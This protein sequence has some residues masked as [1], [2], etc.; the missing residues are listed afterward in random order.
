M[1]VLC[2]H[3][4]LYS[5]KQSILQFHSEIMLKIELDRECNCYLSHETKVQQKNG[6]RNSRLNYFTLALERNTYDIL[7]RQA[8]SIA[9]TNSL[10]NHKQ[11]AV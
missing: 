7:N 11:R 2:I 1:L 6:S 3:T 10:A 4:T 8:F 5:I 9:V